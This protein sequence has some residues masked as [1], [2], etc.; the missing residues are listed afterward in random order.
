[1]QMLKNVLRNL[2]GEPATRAYPF[3][4]REP[5]PG[6]R[7]RIYNDVENCIFCSSCQ[8]ICPTDAITV[9][10]KEGIWNYDPF[11][12]VYCSACVD[13]CPTKCL[14]QECT[15][16]KPSV[17]KF[18]VQRKGTPPKRKEKTPKPAEGGE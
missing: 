5:L 13:K 2:A 14:K 9:D 8:R 3:E 18:M 7:G 11:L 10:A 6:Y 17:Q 16:R 15:H 1:M 12:C 4:V